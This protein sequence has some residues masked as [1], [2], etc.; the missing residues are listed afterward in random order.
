MSQVLFLEPLVDDIHSFGKL[1]EA[2]ILNFKALSLNVLKKASSVIGS[3]VVLGS[4]LAGLLPSG[5]PFIR[6]ITGL[7]SGAE[8]H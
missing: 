8:A 1:T 2:L 5:G 6:G 4:S 7:C 3:A